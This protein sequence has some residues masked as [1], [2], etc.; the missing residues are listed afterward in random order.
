M[1]RALGGAAAAAVV[2]GGA[3]VALGGGEAPATAAPPAAARETATVERADLV[4]RENLA[5]TLGYADTG[6]LA[7]GVSGTLTGLREP[8]TV[9]TRGHSLY[10]VNGEPAAFLL[11]GALP[12]W[13]DFASGMTDGEDV[14]QLERNLRAL[15]YDA[16]TLDDDWDWETTAAVKAFQRDRDLE[17]DGTLARGEIVFRDGATR[18]GEAKGT[19]GES[20]APGRPVAAISSVEREVVVALDARRQHLARRGDKVTVELPTGDEVGGRITSV[21]KVASKAGEE[22]DPTVDVTITLRGH[23]GELDQ[24][25]VDVGFAVEQAKGALAVPVKALLARQGGG[26]A[27]ELPD[28][29]KVQVEA[30]LYADD[31]VE[32]SGDGVREGLKVVTAR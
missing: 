4:D 21:G 27:L 18:I 20:V 14:R 6:T 13:R 29:R 25:P 1:K 7:A 9:V 32:V 2:V 26:Y 17:D 10:S 5:G 8:G 28:G 3:L 12:T 11:Y 30:G 22:S 19:V 16:G 24:A 15:G 31:L 23:R